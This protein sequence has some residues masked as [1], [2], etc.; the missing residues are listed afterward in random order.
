MYRVVMVL[1]AE[2]LEASTKLQTRVLDF[3]E[4]A[5][6]TSLGELESRRLEVQLR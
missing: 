6:G 3:R 2:M 5:W 1:D 4:V